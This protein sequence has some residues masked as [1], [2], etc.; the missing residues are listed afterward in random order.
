MGVSEELIFERVFSKHHFLETP[1]SRNSIIA[2]ESSITD[3]TN[4]NITIKSNRPPCGTTGR[5]VDVF[6][7]SIE[8]H[9]SFI[10]T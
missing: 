3:S 1:F 5:A 2:I 4:P 9:G 10:A 7:R 6:T 8:V